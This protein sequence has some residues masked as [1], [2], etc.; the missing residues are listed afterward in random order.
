MDPRDFYRIVITCRT[1]FFP[2]DEELPVE[3]G[4]LKSGPREAGE[5]PQFTFY[6]IYLSPFSDEQIQ[7]Y[8]RKR[9]SALKNEKRKLASII[10]SKVPNLAVR[11]MLLAYIDDLIDSGKHF[12]NSYQIYTEMVAAWLER[13]RGI[14]KEKDALGEF[15]RKLAVDLVLNREKRKSERIPYKEVEKLAKD[16]GIKLESWKLRGRSL[17]NRDAVGNYKFAHRSILEFLIAKEILDCDEKALSIHPSAWTEPVKRFIFEGHDDKPLCLK[18]SFVAFQGGDYQVKGMGKN[19]KIKP[20]EICCFP[21]TN[22][23]YE[24]FDPD[25]KKERNEYSDH[26]LQPVV[27]TSW[28][29]A[30]KYCEWLT[31]KTGTEYRLPTE[32]EWE[33]AASG[34]GKREYPWG[35]RGPT[36]ELANY[37][38]REKTIASRQAEVS[39]ASKKLMTVFRNR[40]KK[41]EPGEIVFKNLNK[42]SWVGRYPLG[43]TPEGLFDMAGNVWE[44]CEDWYVEKEKYR[45]VRGGSFGNNAGYLRCAPLQL[46]SI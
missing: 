32:A 1:Q 22:L 38:Q 37:F 10:V 41:P 17:L 25:H 43:M 35:D 46:L 3:A 24:L 40:G 12:D 44:W 5:S 11:P 39:I 18:P 16:F 4:I 9:F 14:V 23:E 13:E 2:R 7:K 27:N 30:K 33:F 36:F 21:V 26:D 28:H 19:V 29:D 15:S 8:L 20:F 45:S 42:T 34:G 6:K 31:R